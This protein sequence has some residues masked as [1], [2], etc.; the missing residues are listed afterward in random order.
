MGLSIMGSLEDSKVRRG[1][2]APSTLP[3]RSLA[4]GGLRSC[5][6]PAEESW[7]EK[8]MG[9]PGARAHWSQIHA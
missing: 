6:G 9:A 8:H 5:M 7:G 2:A 3:R 4:S 1:T